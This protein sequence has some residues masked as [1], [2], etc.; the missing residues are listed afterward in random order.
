MSDPKLVSV[1]IPTFNRRALLEQAIQSVL[2]QTYINIEVMIIDDCSTD[3]TASYVQSISDTRVRY[4]RNEQTLFAPESRNVG[5]LKAEGDFIAF[6]DDDDKWLPTKLERQIPLFDD[7]AIGLVYSSITLFYEDY[8]F[9]YNTTPQME[10]AIY[11]DMLIKNYIGGT[12]SVVV[13]KEHLNSLGSQTFFDLDFPAREEY[14]LWIRLSRIC[15]VKFVSEPLVVAYYRNNISRISSDVS[16]YERAI[17]LLN[18]KYAEIITRN[19]TEA[20]I[21]TRIFNQ[22]FFLGSQSIKIGNPKLARKYYFRAFMGKKSPKA[23]VSFILS[24][25]GAKIVIMSKYYFDKYLGVGVAHA[26]SNTQ[27]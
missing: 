17:T 22:N 12:V 26:P 8:N 25:F 14:D 1:I 9:S 5:I 11:K 10:G 18:S 13:R 4:F 21:Q 6:L 7:E 23:L 27:R 20:E 19:L 16:N 3:D 24:F 15:Q 2:N